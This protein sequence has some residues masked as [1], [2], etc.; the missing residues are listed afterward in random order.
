MADR[1][2]GHATVR[3]NMHGRQAPMQCTYNY[4]V[5]NVR[6]YIDF[7]QKLTRWG[8]AGVYRFLPHLNSGPA[9]QLLRQSITVEARQ[10]LIGYSAA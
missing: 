5:S 3:T 2:I 9:A 1:E 6:E 4:P 7:N 10:Q 8:D